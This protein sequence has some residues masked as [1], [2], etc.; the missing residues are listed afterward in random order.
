MNPALY[1]LVYCKD[2][3]YHTQK[4]IFTIQN[5]DKSNRVLKL[6]M[7]VS[8][9]IFAGWKVQ[10]MKFTK[11][12]VICTDKPVL[13]KRFFKNKLNKGLWWGPKVGTQKENTEHGLRGKK[14]ILPK[15][16]KDNVRY[17]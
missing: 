16:S 12:Y 2:Y 7:E 1:G 3:F 9:E 10:N 17:W 11:E 13:V 14:D 4:N 15:V 6:W 5:S 8:H